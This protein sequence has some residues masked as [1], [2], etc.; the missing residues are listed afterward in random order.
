MNIENV[1][2]TQKN[3]AFPSKHKLPLYYV[4]A[5]DGTNVVQVRESHGPTYF[6]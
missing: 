6:L 1:E 5:S 2:A 3:F 4:S